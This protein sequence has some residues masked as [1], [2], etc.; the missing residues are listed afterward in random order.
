MIRIS[1]LGHI[2]EL[3]HARTR[4][5]RRDRYEVVILTNS[6]N[7]EKVRV[8]WKT[9]YYGI[10]EQRYRK[11]RE[12]GAPGW[13]SDENERITQK[14]LSTIGDIFQRESIDSSRKLLE[15]GCGDGSVSLSLA[16]RGFDV[17]GIDISST[18]ILWAQEKA[19]TQ[20]LKA[21]FRTGSVVDLPYSD[22]DFDAVIDVACSHCIIGEDRKLLFAEA[23]RVLKCDG[24]FLSM[25]LC[26][27]PAEEE[28]IRDFDPVSRCIVRDGVAG[29]YFGRPEDIVQE[30][31][32][33]GFLSVSREVRRNPAHCGQ[34]YL[35]AIDR[36]PE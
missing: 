14:K 27:D 36:K 29:R 11:L 7:G 15:L 25:V 34:E 24:L 13:G 23:F 32:S 3:R 6:A 21:E 31:A 1:D 17:C 2:K 28:T 16:Q 20:G 5:C 9:D 10:H 30:M 12:T 22:S 8:M 26:G 35:R 33:A 19:R 4:P 18:A